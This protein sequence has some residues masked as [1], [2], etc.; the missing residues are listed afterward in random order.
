MLVRRVTSTALALA[1]L[2]GG[3]A[4]AGSASHSVQTGSAAKQQYNTKPGCGPWK[5][6]GVAGS[7]GRHTG[8]PPKAPDRADCPK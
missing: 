7:S 4:F 6:D 8:Q 1:V 5:T 3:V 2:G